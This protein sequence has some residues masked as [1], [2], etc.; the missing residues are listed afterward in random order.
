MFR[1]SQRLRFFNFKSSR[2]AFIFP[3]ALPLVAVPVGFAVCDTD[4]KSGS[5]QRNV[6]AASLKAP[7]T[8]SEEEAGR[9]LA[10]YALGV[11]SPDPTVDREAPSESFFVGPTRASR[12]MVFS[13]SSSYELA[14]EV[15]AHLDRYMNRVHTGRFADGECNIRAVDD[16]RGADCFIIQSYPRNDSAGTVSDC[17]MET[18]LMAS[19]LKRSSARSVTLVMPYVPYSRQLWSGKGSRDPDWHRPFAGSDVC[20]MLEAVGVDRMICVDIHHGS[21]EGCLP[22]NIPVEII[23]PQSLVVKY[24][25]QGKLEL[26]NPVVVAPDEVGADNAKKFYKL[27]K[28][29]H[30]DASVATIV[31]SPA[32]QSALVKDVSGRDC[33][34][35]DDI[36]DTGGR[37]ARTATLLKASGARSV[38]AYMSHGILSDGAIETLNACP[39][40]EILVT[41]S[42][43][44]RRDK[45]CEKITIISAASLL[46]E[47]I[48]R[49]QR[50]KSVSSMYTYGQDAV[51]P[52]ELPWRDSE[53]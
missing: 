22:P 44:P 30:P 37:L 20:R 34:I 1:Y 53:N 9:F 8:Q 7:R 45:L 18:L 38:I 16:V 4:V 13:G 27:L 17:L 3:A 2:R 49:V 14:A 25:T 52:S 50:S 33:I 42:I 41:N 46:A 15:C 51:D 40:S 6:D 23:D 48:R 26:K 21:F 31:N 29:H 11:T 47:T 32:L 5:D 36:V 12:T 43:K 10:E 28:R 39:V 19:A 35:I 24:L